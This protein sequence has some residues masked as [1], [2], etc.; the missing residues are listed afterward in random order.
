[1]DSCGMLVSMRAHPKHAP[2]TAEELYGLPDDGARHELASGRLLSEPPPGL[3]HG[4]VL[5]TI[6]S[7]LR[8]HVR[9]R[10]LGKVYGG[11]SG[12]LLSR[13]PDTVR[14]PDVA[15]VRAERVPAGRLRSYYPGAP[16]LAVE[17]LSPHDRPGEVAAKI[18]DY[19]AAGTRAVWVLDSE[20]QCVTVFHPGAPAEMLLA[21]DDL[22]GGDVVPG[23]R[24]RVAEIFEP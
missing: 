8:D 15:F 3:D 7:L 13:A 20:E 23:F 11:D 1:M 9:S 22:D 2:M 17:I 14:A 10:K 4:D 24:V 16:D 5:I 12:F 18:T 19:L 21:G 6:G